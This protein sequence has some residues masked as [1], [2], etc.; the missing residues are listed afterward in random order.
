MLY[1]TLPSIIGTACMPRFDNSDDSVLVALGVP[2]AEILPRQTWLFMGFAG[3][4][5]L[6]VFGILN[7]KQ[8]RAF[9]SSSLHV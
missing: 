6:D 7:L 8:P 9:E 2:T 4:H 5:Y 1:H 3:S